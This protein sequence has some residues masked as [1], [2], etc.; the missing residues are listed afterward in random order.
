MAMVFRAS[1]ALVLAGVLLAGCS[2]E[3]GV[4][5]TTG[6]LGTQTATA[7][8]KVDPACVTLAAKIDGLRKEGIAD[9][10]EKAAAKKYKMTHSDLLKADQLMKADADF[11]GRCATI[12]PKPNTAQASPAPV[13]TASAASGPKPS[14]LPKD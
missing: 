9:K 8:P 4:G 13:A 10:I 3:N 1:T 7:E 5:F 6:A 2:G 14:V 11:Q 12:A